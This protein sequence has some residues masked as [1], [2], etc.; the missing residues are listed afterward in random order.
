MSHDIQANGANEV[1]GR[2]S[3]RPNTLRLP[4]KVCWKSVVALYRIDA[5]FQDTFHIAAEAFHPERRR[6]AHSAVK[7]KLM[8]GKLVR[9][10]LKNLFPDFRAYERHCQ[11]IPSSFHTESAAPQPIL[12]C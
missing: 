5:A 12:A 3:L 7:Q 10:R 4:R 11:M 1:L 2:K 8:F 6:V 9:Q